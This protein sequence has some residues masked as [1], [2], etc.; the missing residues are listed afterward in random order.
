MRN[1]KT[2]GAC[3][4]NITYVASAFNP[5]DWFFRLN[6]FYQ[7]LLG[8]AAAIVVFA[9]G[10]K[11]VLAFYEWC[12]AKYDDVIL[13]NFE[14]AL[15]KAKLNNPKEYIALEPIPLAEI[16]KH[17]KRSQ[18]SVNKSLRRLK[19]RQKLKELASGW[20]LA[21]QETPRTT[22]WVNSSSRIRRRG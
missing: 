7:T 16:A 17:V 11:I 2:D 4:V 21:E 12:L 5:F 9:G 1:V 13:Q 14:E 6:V 19:G 18:A 20:I 10:W 8:T 22:D 3:K 15:R